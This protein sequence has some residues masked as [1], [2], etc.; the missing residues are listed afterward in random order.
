MDQQTQANNRIRAG[1]GR[2]VL[3][4]HFGGV[5]VTLYAMLYLFYGLNFSFLA[6]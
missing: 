4:G 2:F 3:K 5:N 6:V 1:L